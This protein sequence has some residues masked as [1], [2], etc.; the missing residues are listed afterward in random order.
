MYV[1][2]HICK[3]HVCPR[4]CSRAPAQP[5]KGDDDRGY[6]HKHA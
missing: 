1:Y 2:L 3:S 6:T 5:A 4:G